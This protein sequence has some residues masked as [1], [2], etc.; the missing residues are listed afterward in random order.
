MLLGILVGK[1][2]VD[3]PWHLRRIRPSY[4]RRVARRMGRREWI[5]VLN[6]GLWAAALSLVAV[7]GVRIL[8]TEAAVPILDPKEY[9]FTVLRE[10]YP[11]VLLVVVN[12]LPIFEE[13]IFRGILID[14][15]YVRRK[16][17]TGAIVFSSLLFSIFHL[18]NPGTYPAFAL[19]IFPS[20]LFLGVCYIKVGL[21][22]AV[23]AHNVYNSFLVITGI[24][25]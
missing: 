9:P 3:N 22:G 14:E 24:M 10:E 13:W 20:A 15:Y 12:I 25:R 18:S 5:R 16:S 2:L 4:W 8:L 7:T 21:G 17:W 23:L 1:L 11:L 19:A 6:F